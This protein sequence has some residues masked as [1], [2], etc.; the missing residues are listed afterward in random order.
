MLD[1]PALFLGIDVGTGGVRA[2]A[3]THSGAVAA[4][5]SVPLDPASVAIDAGRHEQSADAWWAAV[6]RACRRLVESLQAAGHLPGQLAALCV[7]GTSGTVVPLDH[8]GRPLRTA[9]MYNDPRA[10]AEAERLN[11]AAGPFCDKLGYRF[12]ASYALA[13]ILWLREH[14]PECFRLTAAMVHQADYVVLR[15][16]GQGGQ[17]PISS[18]TSGGQG[19]ACPTKKGT[20]PCCRPVTDSSNALKT[21][22][23]L[24]DERWPAWIETFD[25]VRERLPEV[26]APGT[27]IGAV[28]GEAAEQTGLP[29]GLPVVAGAT[30]GA[31]AFL[32]SGACRPGDYNTTLGTTLVFKGVS[33]RICRHPQGLIYCHKLPGGLWLPGAASNTGGE[34]I[35][36]WFAGADP[37]AMDAA[38]A[39]RLPCPLVAYPLVRPGE[40]FPFLCPAARGFSPEAAPEDRYA[41]CLE[42]VAFLER[43]AY[44]VMDRAAGTS[45]GE[46]FGTGGGSRSD[47]WM[48]CRADTTGRTVHRPSTP[49]SAFGAAVLAAAG[50][51]HEGLAET[52]RAMVRVVRTFLPDP[53]RAAEYESVYQRFCG[54][55]VKRGYLEHLQAV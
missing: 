36:A 55:L 52:Q 20:V 46:V 27:R 15:L 6:S 50:T 17:S 12:N 53:A 40:R 44:D 14:E 48:Q 7:D 29:A 22:Y 5:A 25:G 18:A 38:A 26:V 4:E 45:G 23:D 39:G 19:E 10:A 21:G 37:R 24:V 9:L 43:L 8:A 47:V 34:W 13:K 30:D 54:E 16:A 51:A 1:D 2:M 33:R 11:T 28:S 32:A 31:A 42:G 49:E 3:V 41:A 35:G